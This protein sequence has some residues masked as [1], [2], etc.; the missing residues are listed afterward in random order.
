[1]KKS[2]DWPIESFFEILSHNEYTK[3]M[4]H[5]K[6]GRHKLVFICREELCKGK[7]IWLLKYLR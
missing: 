2:N 5:V 7:L 1:M 3:K 6:F 4:T